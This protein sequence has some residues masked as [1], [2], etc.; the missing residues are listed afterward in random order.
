MERQVIFRDRQEMQAA[1]LNNVQVFVDESLQ[2]IILDAITGERQY[3]G[4][5]VTS[6]SATE[7]NIA[8]GRL[9]HGDEGKIFRKDQ[10]E[11]VSIFSYLPVSD[12]KWL[13]VSLSG[14]EQETD[15]Q[16]RDF[17]I[18]LDTG[19]TE[20]ASVAMET[21]RAA[22][23]TINA[24]IESPDPQKPAAPTGY[25]TIAYVRLNSSGV[26]EIEQADNKELMRLFE[27]SQTVSA[28][29]KWIDEKTA[30]LADLLSDL[31]R[32]MELA[33][34]NTSGMLIGDLVRDVAILKDK[35]ELPDSYVSYGGDNFLTKDECD[36]ANTDYYARCEEGIRFPWA[37][38]TEQQPAL[39]N[40]LADE[41]KNHDG[42]ILPAYTIEEQNYTSGYSGSLAI[43]QYAYQEHTMKQGSR[44]YRRVRFGPERNVCTN[45]DEQKA[46]SFNWVENV[47]E[48]PASGWQYL[49]KFGE[50]G[51]FYWVRYR[52]FWV[53]IITENYWYIATTDYVINGSQVAQTF[54][55][56]GNRWVAGVNLYFDKIGTDGDVHVHLCET[57]LGQPDPTKCLATTT[58]AAADLKIRPTA[59]VADFT[60]PAF[61]EAGKR[62][63]ILLT[64]A[65]THEAATIQGTQYTQGTV[66]SCT[67]GAYFTGDH[68]KDLMFG[69]RYA[70]FLNTRTTV[71]MTTM[72][73]SDGIADF[74]FIS[75]LVEPDGTEF[76]VEFQMEGD[77]NW[78]PVVQENAEQ[79]LGLPA[80]VHLR[81][82]FVGTQSLQP[83]LGLTGSRWQANRAASTFKHISTTRSLG[84]A[85]ENIDVVLQLENWDETKHACTVKLISGGTT[86][87]HDSV[88]DVV[89]ADADDPT[90]RR[91]FNF[92]PEPGTGITEYQIQIE[93]TTTTVLD[94]FHVAYRTDVAK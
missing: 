86:Y 75:E 5:L 22:Q 26:Q 82:V 84:A 94:L 87:T 74:D 34:R 76:V 79:L 44:T 43:G 68:E 4:C 92:L 10:A 49:G 91:T 64:T 90:I 67:D 56:S 60:Q 29:A 7:I 71:E 69:I 2:H 39:F 73:L 1:D 65:G 57:S 48:L 50:H 16:P 88:S 81:A 62:Y 15:I 14:V 58:V 47:Y 19:Q 85:S 42:L 80:M 21:A 77:S 28:H 61:L 24:G 27:V 72:S 30:V 23:V 35:A 25:T 20:P 63:A 38:Q 31:T 8:S 3:T 17:L 37:G 83:G 78:Y 66:F 6:P 40:P 89:M 93:G 54:L 52:Q 33:K 12:E 32:L 53:D 41:V 9:W 11:T 70:K 45:S 13:A 55:N 36:L 51:D 59:T 18:D 46:P